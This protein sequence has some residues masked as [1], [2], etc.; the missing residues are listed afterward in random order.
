MNQTMCT[1]RKNESKD[2]ENETGILK[3]VPLIWAGSFVGKNRENLV[4]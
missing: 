1:Q 3:I 2:A 4:E